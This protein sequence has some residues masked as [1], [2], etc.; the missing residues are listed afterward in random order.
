MAEA[1]FPGLPRTKDQRNDDN[2]GSHPDGNV[3][4]LIQ[5]R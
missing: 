4:G 1:K 2:P 5:D 3:L